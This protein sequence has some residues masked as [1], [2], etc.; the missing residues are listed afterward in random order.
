MPELLA[1]AG[2]FE[3]VKAAMSYGADAVYLGGQL[4]QLRAKRAAFDEQTLV[5]TLEYVHARGKKVYVTMNSFA[6]NDEI[7]AAG[8]YALHLHKLGAD[9]FIISDLGILSHVKDVCPEAEVHVSTQANCTNW[10][11]AMAY[12]SMGAKR[13]VLAREMTM[14]EISRLRDKIPDDLEIE[15]FIHGAMCMAYSGRCI[16]SSYLNARSGNRG[17]CTQPCRWKYQLVEETRP[18]LY[19][20]IEQ[21]G[22]FT[23][24][25]SGHDLCMI[26]HLKELEDAGVSSFKIEGRMKT[27]YYVATVVNAYRRAMDGTSSI[28]YCERELDAISHRPYETGFYYGAVKHE[29]ANSGINRAS[30]IFVGS[31]LASEKGEITVCQRNKFSVGDTLEILTPDTEVRKFKVEYIKNELGES[32]DS[33]PNP[34]Q[35]V[36]INCPFEL[37]R[38]DILR[39]R[40]ETVWRS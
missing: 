13:V 22:E 11:T 8:E 36:T 31:V 21:E 26:N 35:I 3:C 17:E 18:G 19:M 4:L 24:I 20:P 34:K 23:S 5:K 10:R 16:L 28:E 2:D 9:A 7:E 15:C 30:C 29:H 12:Y 14:A 39:R 33:A 25:L 27:E 32:M 40:E 37:K 38:D 1:P 6:R